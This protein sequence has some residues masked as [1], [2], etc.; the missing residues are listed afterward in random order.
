MNRLR[1]DDRLHIGSEYET[2]QLGL[3]HARKQTL[4]DSFLAL[5]CDEMRRLF[6]KNCLFCH[7][8]NP[9]AVLDIE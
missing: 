8:Q 6:D 4:L 5:S 1:E 3:T 7:V 9:L 2:H